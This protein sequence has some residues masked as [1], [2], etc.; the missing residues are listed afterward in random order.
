MGCQKT[1]ASKI[2][3]KEADYILASKG[4]HETFYHEVIKLFDNEV[5]TNE[6]V[7]ENKGHGR[8]ETR[9]CRV[10]SASRLP[11]PACIMPAFAAAG[12]N[13]T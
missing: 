6:S 10:I 1:I 11:D 4:N 9:V 13:C 7:Q 5:L 2:V 12:S 3:E 8:F